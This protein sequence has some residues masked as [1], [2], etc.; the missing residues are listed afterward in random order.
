MINLIDNINVFESL[1]KYSIFN[2]HLKLWKMYGSDVC[3]IIN[4][5]C[6]VELERIVRQVSEKHQH[7]LMTRLWNEKRKT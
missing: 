3:Q 1:N 7:F 6:H 5:T 4:Q 2:E